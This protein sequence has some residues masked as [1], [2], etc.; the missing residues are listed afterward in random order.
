MP[1]NISSGTGRLGVHS[2]MPLTA[3]TGANAI[4]RIPLTQI[5]DDVWFVGNHYVGQ[6]IMKT[7]DGL[8]Q[9]DSGNN[10][11]EFATFNH[12]GMQTLGLSASY[13]LKAIFLTH[14]HGDHDGGAR[15]LAW[16]QLHAALRALT[17][18]DA[19]A[20]DTRIG[21]PGPTAKRMDRAIRGAGRERGQHQRTPQAQACQGSE[22]R[23]S[24]KDQSTDAWLKPGNCN[25]ATATSSKAPAACAASRSR[26]SWTRRSS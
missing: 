12:P 13:P 3:D 2:F 23:M 8:V 1:L 20:I 7:A 15:E 11:N 18:D 24:E 10:A 19:R 21:T 14:G 4:Y 16:D 26:R 17:P 25:S 9:V 5:F 22:L 6:Y